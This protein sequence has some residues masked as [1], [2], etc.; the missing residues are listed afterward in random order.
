MVSRREGMGWITPSYSHEPQ[1][2]EPGHRVDGQ[3][4]TR[5][6]DE[7]LR[8]AGQLEE[9]AHPAMLASD[10]DDVAAL[11]ARRGDFDRGKHRATECRYLHRAASVC[12]GHLATVWHEQSQAS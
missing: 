10:L 8:S 1:G 2:H 9:V 4:L 6:E 12:T 7:S 5:V 11:H 3:Q